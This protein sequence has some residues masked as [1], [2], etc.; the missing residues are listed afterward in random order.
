MP[1]DVSHNRAGC[2][3]LHPDLRHRGA[4]ATRGASRA[5]TRVDVPPPLAMTALSG[6]SVAVAAVCGT[7]SARC[8]NR[9][10]LFQSEQAATG[11]PD[12]FCGACV[13]PVAR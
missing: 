2:P 7:G 1:H 13:Y 5:D 6:S 4:V 3:E 9:Y 12:A 11:I 10:P 8:G